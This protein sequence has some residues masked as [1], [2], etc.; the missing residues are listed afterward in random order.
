MLSVR[1]I[2]P[3]KTKTL[4][5]LFAS[6][7][8]GLIA[9]LVVLSLLSVPVSGQDNSPYSRYGIGDLV[10]PTHV[11]GRGMAGLSAAYSDPLSIN[12]ANPA[13][14]A[15]FQSQKELKSKKLAWGRAILDVGINVDSR[16]L[17]EPASGKKFVASNA[18][19]SYVQ[20]GVPVKQNWGLSFGIRPISRVSYNIFRTERLYDPLTSL[21]IDSA[22]TIFEGKGGSYLA[23]MGTGFTIFR[24]KR[25]GGEQRLSMGITA[26]YF[27]GE[28]DYKTRRYFN[29]DTVDYKQANY[30]TKTNFGNIYFSGGLQYHLPIGKKYLFS[31]GAYGTVKQKIGATQDIVRET[32][33]FDDTQGEL[34]LDSVSDQRNL[35]GKLEMPTSFTFGFSFQKLPVLNKQGG[36]LVGVD[37]AQQNW[38]QYRFYGKPDSVRNSWELRVGG[39][40]NPMPSTRNYFSNVTYRFG[41][42]MGPDYIQL[43][44]KKLSRFGGSLGLGLPIPTSRQAPNQATIVNLALEYTKRGGNDNYLKE[45]LFR[46]SLGFSLSDFWFIKRKYD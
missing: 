12:F 31:A 17:R 2:T 14:F 19:F 36:W 6:R 15:N 24:N 5:R 16:A 25:E 32:Y 28:K 23:N 37:F 7:Q 27:F 20:V 26:G 43:N 4:H 39:Q 46:I 9:F 33:T 44:G 41:L 8:L 35:K 29:N 42:S 13:S 10:S 11:N 40:L 21:P 30:E 18:L 38:S 45:N 34:R 22:T 1:S 3:K